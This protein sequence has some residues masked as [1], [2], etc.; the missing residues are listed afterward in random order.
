MIMRAWEPW[1]SMLVCH[2]PDLILM[3]STFLFLIPQLVLILGLDSVRR[4]RKN[5]P[6]RNV[7]INYCYYSWSYCPYLKQ[8]ISMFL[9]SIRG[10]LFDNFFLIISPS[11]IWQTSRDLWKS[12][13]MFFLRIGFNNSLHCTYWVLIYISPIFML[14]CVAVSCCWTMCGSVLL[15]TSDVR[16][17]VFLALLLWTS[18]SCWGSVWPM[19]VVMVGSV[20]CPKN[21][22][23]PSH[24][25]KHKMY[26][27]FACTCI[28]SHKIHNP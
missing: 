2:V 4:Q 11:K 5:T 15:L 27:I 23:F 28:W 6:K 17:A 7:H 12:S 21:C 13:F 20:N 16:N 19:V 24:M 14:V 1:L 10:R 18:H 8:A 3:K 22:L 26:D 9:T 25:D